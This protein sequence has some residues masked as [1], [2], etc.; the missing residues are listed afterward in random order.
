MNE[1]QTKEMEDLAFGLGEISRQIAD[2]YLTLNRLQAVYNERYH[3]LQQLK[4][5]FLKENE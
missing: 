5:K 2:I 3:E 4:V 1:V